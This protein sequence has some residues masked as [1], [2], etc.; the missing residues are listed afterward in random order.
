MN[1][2]TQPCPACHG[3]GMQCSDLA[4][5]AIQ[6]GHDVITTWWVCQECEGAKVIPADASACHEDETS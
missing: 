1:D 4:W 5:R 3:T 6:R 2:T